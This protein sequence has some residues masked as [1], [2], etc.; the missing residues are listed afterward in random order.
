MCVC[1]HVCV[2][3]CVCAVTTT[4][5]LYVQWIPCGDHRFIFH[6][7]HIAFVHLL[8]GTRCRYYWTGGDSL[9]ELLDGADSVIVRRMG[10]GKKGKGK[11]GKGKYWSTQGKGHW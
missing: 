9:Q 10:K 7:S 5:C 1:V 2:H 8:S 4:V 11:K 6:S 3:A